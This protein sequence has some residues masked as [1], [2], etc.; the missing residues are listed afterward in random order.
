M[1]CEILYL[2]HLV[3]AQSSGQNLDYVSLS[4]REGEILGVTGVSESG[5]TVLADVIC[6]HTALSSGA[7]Y[8]DGN[9]V[10]YT[11]CTEARR[12][13]IYE[14]TYQAA[15]VSDMT[16]T[17][18]LT[19]LHG[20]E[21]W[22]RLLN[23]RRLDEITRAIFDQYG[24]AGEPQKK[25]MWLSGEQRLELSVCRALLCGA[26][27][28]VCREPG[29]GL[30]QDEL[31]G[32]TRFLR[33]LSSEGMSVIVFNSDV[34]KALRYSDRVVVMRGGMVCWECRSSQATAAD[35]YRRMRLAASHISIESE[36]VPLHLFATLQDIQLLK[37]DLCGLTAELYAG[38]ATGVLC[39]GVEGQGAIYRMFSCAEPVSGSVLQNEKREKFKS[40]RRRQGRTVHCLRSRFW[41]D[42]IFENLT[43]AEN[44]LFRSLH[45]FNDRFGVMNQRIL[46]LAM[47][48]FAAE[49]GF[50]PDGLQEYPRHLSAQMR[51]QLVLLRVLFE[52]PRLLVLDYPFYTIDEQIKSDLLQCVATL[53]EKGTAVLWSS[54]DVPTLQANWEQMVICES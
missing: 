3:T 50:D 8:L 46:R 9:R 33:Q 36:F 29:E 40:W 7:I 27:V 24:I 14:I 10:H 54:N 38:R 4:L 53:R 17:E 26:R 28:L 52:P 6:G 48:D 11:S 23:K 32:F 51:N 39:R 21:G 15:V 20:D 43:A 35:I 34:H 31:I 41:E 42:G 37:S 45:R 19:V 25:A 2:E 18:N 44:I 47:H 16:A 13:G 1:S 5:M 22:G 30:S 49:N 12:L